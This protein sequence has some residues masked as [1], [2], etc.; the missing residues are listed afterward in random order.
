MP[1]ITSVELQAVNTVF[2]SAD[3]N[4]KQ[5][6]VTID[7]NQPLPLG[8]YVF[9]L[10]VEDDANNKSAPATLRLQVVDTTAPNA[11]IR[12]DDR[13][14]FRK[15]F[16]LSGEGSFDPDNGKITKYRWTRIQ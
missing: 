6:I 9:E 11:V 15:G 7:A 1:K 5:L 13:V 16:I 10:V 14:P 4:D 3:A 2:E 12:G 8:A